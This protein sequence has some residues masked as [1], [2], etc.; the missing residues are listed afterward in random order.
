[1]KVP[2]LRNVGLRKRFMHT[3]EFESLG[4]AISF[5]R[6]GPA[7]PE[8]DDIPGGGIYAFN[9]G[10]LTDADIRSFLSKALT[11]PRVRD[12]LFPF[13]RPTLRTE[14][15]T[16]DTH[17]PPTPQSFAATRVEAEIRLSWDPHPDV[18]DYVL[19]RD[20]EVIAL[21]TEPRFFDPAQHGAAKYRL[22]ARDRA[23]N[24]APATE[25]AVAPP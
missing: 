10:A 2:S 22:V 1:M 6:T 7:L 4:A 18:A 12:E 16:V 9:M 3:G 15:E 11:D 5:Y 20:D 23:Q 25:L 24:E 8:R 13:D 19:W 14:G 21:T 17:P